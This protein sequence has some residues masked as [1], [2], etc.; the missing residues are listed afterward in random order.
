MDPRSIENLSKIVG[1]TYS[2]YLLLDNIKALLTSMN[3]K[4]DK[5]ANCTSSGGY[6]YVA[7]SSHDTGHWGRS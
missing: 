2:M 4:L 3:E 1:N 7:Q 5:L 6:I